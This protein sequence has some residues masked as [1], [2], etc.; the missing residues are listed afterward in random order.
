MPILDPFAAASR[1][2]PN[3]DGP[4]FPLP[5]A[6]ALV[7]LDPNVAAPPSL[8]LPKPRRT[9][10]GDG[11]PTAF[12]P[13]PYG[14]TRHASQ[15]SLL[16]RK[17]LVQ[18]ATPPGAK[19]IGSDE[20]MQEEVAKCV[21]AAE[22]TLNISN[23]GLETI[24]T[25]IADLRN[26]VTLFVARSPTAS[27]VLAAMA[28]SRLPP[29]PLVFVDAPSSPGANIYAGNAR[30]FSRAVSAP[31]SSA[32]F[33]D[34]LARAAPRAVSGVIPESPSMVASDPPATLAPPAA[35]ST[36]PF[37]EKRAFGRSKTGAAVLRTAP[38][39]KA[40]GRSMEV[41]AASNM[42]KSLPSALFEI[43]NLTMLSL[44]SNQLTSLP[45]AIG[46]LK[47]L[48]ELNISNNRITHLPSTI[49]NLP[50]E[51]FSVHPNAWIARPNNADTSSG[52]CLA[53]L[54][55]HTDSPVASLKD[56]CV[57]VL[58]SPRAPIGLAP[59][60][61]YDWEPRRGEVHPLSSPAVL[62]G[63]IPQLSEDD[64][65]RTLQALRS[66]GAAYAQGSVLR[67][68]M[69]SATLRLDPFPRSYHTAPPDDA[70]LNPY[71]S[72]CPAPKHL[73][74]DNYAELRMERR[75][76][77]HAAEERIEWRT[78]CG[79]NDLPIQWQG[80]SPGCLAFLEEDE[81]EWGLDDDADE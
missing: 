6:A 52:R 4:S 29:S 46:E 61:E 15:S 40:S 77:L 34:I 53:P 14:H 78:V 62:H 64:L 48:K 9:H 18:P 44:R 41:Y 7:P 57:Q 47:H 72:H 49:L 30:S 80:C 17:D 39:A 68:S 75:L 31:V 35:L 74:V 54:N 59:M 24:S 66:A 27:P 45:A 23:K 10:H 37:G 21:D 2:M 33:A 43:T 71:Y 32:F 42:L 36:T 16:T 81:D 60:F 67:S 63:I 58:L 50:L 20:W 22:Y 55:R 65:A 69:T 19:R 5:F 13:A 25:K 3:L 70:S 51:V 11:L 79:N 76:F 1:P 56:L 12:P 38:L 26:L 28:F 8:P 73:E